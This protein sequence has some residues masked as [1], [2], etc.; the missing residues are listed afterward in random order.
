MTRVLYR[1]ACSAGAS[2]ETLGEAYQVDYP[3]LSLAS[4]AAEY[5]T[6]LSADTESLCYGV[7]Y[8]VDAIDIWEAQAQWVTVDERPNGGPLLYVFVEI[9]GAAV[10]IYRWRFADEECEFSS[11]NADVTDWLC[12]EPG[13]RAIVR[14]WECKHEDT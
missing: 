6:E 9:D 8:W 3:S 2:A 5:L 13:I 4:D 10:T 11:M 7:T 12:S 14:A 1:V